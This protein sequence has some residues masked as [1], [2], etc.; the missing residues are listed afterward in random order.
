MLGK[1]DL[2]DGYYIKK[3]L[4][5]FEIPEI[6]FKMGILKNWENNIDRFR[7]KNEKQLQ[8]LFFNEIFVKLLGYESISTDAE[9]WTIQFEEST[10]IDSSVP[11][12]ILGLYSNNGEKTKAVIELKG[13][14]VND[15]DKKQKRAN[16][17]Y[18]SPVDQCYSYANKYDGCEWIIVSNM[19]EIRLY[20]NGQSQH[21]YEQFFISDIANNVSEFKKF[22]FLLRKEELVEK[23][24]VLKINKES[25]QKK[26]KITQD[27]YEFYSRARESLWQSLQNHNTLLNIHSD[28]LLEK[29]QK[30]LN[31]ITFILFC[32]AN[33]LIP[34]GTL[35][36]F[37]FEG[38]AA[39]S[40]STWKY[41]HTLFYYIDKGREIDDINRFNGGLFKADRILDEI[42]I[43]DKDFEVIEEFFTY[44]FR[45]GLTVDVLGHIFEQSISD[46]EKLKGIE[47]LI[48]NR[49]EHGIF[50]TP[51]YVTDYIVRESIDQWIEQEKKRLGFETLKDWREIENKGWQTRYI[52][53]RIE[54]LNKLKESLS[55]IKILDPTCGSGAFLT[56]VFEYLHKKHQEIFDEVTELNAGHNTTSTKEY[57]LDMDRDILV[58]NI[59]GIDLNKESVEITKLSLWLKTANKDKELT[60]LDENIIVGNTVID[61]EE[62][63]PNGRINWDMAFPGVKEKGGFDIILGNPPYIPIDFLDQETITH[64]QENFKEILK[65]KWETSI[66]FMYKSA[67]LLNKNGILSMIVPVTW[68]TGINYS[69][70]RGQFLKKR[71][72]LTR[73]IVMPSNVFADAYV[74]TCIFM[75][76]KKSS[77]IE[78]ENLSFLGYKYPLNH[79]ISAIS[80]TEIDM[81]K[82]DNGEVFNHDTLKVFPNLSNYTLYKRIKGFLKDTQNFVKLGSVTDSTQG[83]VES[84]Y[85]YTYIKRDNSHLPY[86]K[87]GQGYRYLL[88][89]EEKNFID[90]AQKPKMH[91][92]Y[93]GNPRLYARRIINRQDR[94][95]FCYCEEDLV[96]KKELNP[97]IVID[98]RIKIRS[99]YAILNSKLISYIY[100]N[101]SSIALKDDYRQTTLTELR[102]L[103]IK[104]LNNEQNIF[105]ETQVLALEEAIDKYYKKRS[106][107]ISIIE[108]IIGD[109]ISKKLSNFHQLS[110]SE[111]L[112][113]IKRRNKN[114]SKSELEELYQLYLDSAGELRLLSNTIQEIDL[115]VEDFVYDIY[116]LTVEERKQ[117]ND[118]Y[119]KFNNP[120]SIQLEL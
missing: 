109:M 91:K 50:Y 90:F 71:L 22:Y 58:N 79:K 69:D 7:G 111:Y 45:N 102:D 66:I 96:T 14:D 86:L 94:L 108:S 100:I 98:D 88:K 118:Y 12:G 6:Q 52:Q 39:S 55:N 84:Q 78:S 30:I 105:L 63:N 43:P 9:E 34:N 59:F 99:L 37:Y 49:K 82:I 104:V 24:K 51:E 23:S 18:G 44:D 4:E 33:D 120:S 68:L 28:D 2:F 13:L 110:S 77:S 10:E 89:I 19:F 20:R 75:G 80:I 11:D 56:K 29:A 31:R 54:L 81:D 46:I 21:Y 115:I 40:L 114:I 36:K 3:E 74:D 1:F 101:F 76:Q 42:D 5:S 85:N 15:L 72:D 83:P 32:E 65:N 17:N 107:S 117:I 35:K 8:P 38:K 113:E 95:M 92:F 62:L 67:Q 116:D 73:L 41:L 47:T 64:Y 61:D 93:T 60:T 26:Q 48:G 16:K 97:F 70:F 27:F 106:Y 119:N 87:S 57:F 25:F 53:D 112:K 103:P